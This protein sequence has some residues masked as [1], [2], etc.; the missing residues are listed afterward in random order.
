M[1]AAVMVA[2]RLV[3]SELGGRLAGCADERFAWPAPRPTRAV[4]GQRDG[5]PP[6]AIRVLLLNV[7]AF[8]HQRASQYTLTLNPTTPEHNPTRNTQAMVIIVS[9]PRA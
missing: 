5:L 4:E 2:V 8:R 6:R 1:I 3:G 7:H 9:P